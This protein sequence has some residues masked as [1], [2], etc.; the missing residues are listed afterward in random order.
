MAIISQTRVW[1]GVTTRIDTNTETGAAYVYARAGLLGGDALLF[2]SEG[3]G[4]DWIV[5]NPQTVANLYNASNGTDSTAQEVA[6]AF[7][8]QGHRVYDNDRAAVLNNPDNYS[9]P[10][11]AKIRQKSFFDNNLPGIIN[12]DTNIRVNGDTTVPTVPIPLEVIP[13]PDGDNPPGGDSPPPIETGAGEDETPATVNQNFGALK[14]PLNDPFGLDY[15]KIDIVGYVPSLSLGGGFLGSG[16]QSA[17]RRYQDKSTKGT[18]LLP[19]QPALSETSSI[20]WG[21]DKLNAFQ[22]IAAGALGGA[23]EALGTFG[24]Y[25]EL[26]QKLGKELNSLGADANKILT[27]QQLE[28]FVK[29]YFAGKIVG[30]N[31]LGRSTGSV[32]NPN[33]ELLFNGPRL[34]QF[35]FNFKLTPREPAEA[36]VIREIIF[37]LKKHSSPKRSNGQLFLKF[38]DIFKLEYV[39]QGSGQHPFM[40]KFKPCALTQVSVDY[41]PDGSYMTY[42]E[43]GSMTSYN[44][45]LSFGEIEPNYEDEY[46]NP[47]DMGF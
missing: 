34:R 7:I 30:A 32:I 5:R 17:T 46:Q 31:V 33:L 26:K 25:E 36:S 24:N 15:I 8:S 44:L 43:N 20:D 18:I 27:D 47:S 19:M 22:A 6:D 37:R 2:T 29:S 3:K 16:S 11:E 1:N 9:S 41:T 10:E 13:F 38:P 4:G 28:G 14:Y 23:M 35:N 42:G 39:Y 45:A 12:P 40:N 21:D